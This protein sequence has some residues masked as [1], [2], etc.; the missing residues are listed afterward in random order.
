MIVL[1]KLWFILYW[2]FMLTLNLP[3]QLEQRLSQWTANT[4]QSK[5]YGVQRALEEFLDD[6]E[7]YSNALRVAERVK[8][9]QEPTYTLEEL[10]K[11]H[12][13]LDV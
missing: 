3:S 6:Y 9:G 7:D 4:H 5:E 13:L 12:D 8:N 11:R 1:L 2:F 10:K